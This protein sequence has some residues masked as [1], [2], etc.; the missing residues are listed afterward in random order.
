MCF[1]PSLLLF[2]FFLFLQSRSLVASLSSAGNTGNMHAQI[3]LADDVALLIV[4][5]VCPSDCT[6]PMRCVYLMI[7]AAR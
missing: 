2:P 6:V 4:N 1:L 5:R 7:V 3:V